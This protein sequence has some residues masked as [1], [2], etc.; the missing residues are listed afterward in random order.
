MLW[1]SARFWSSLSFWICS[2]FAHFWSSLSIWTCS[3][4]CLAVL[5]CIFSLS[6]FG[7]CPPVGYSNGYPKRTPTGNIHRSH[8]PS[9]CL[10]VTL[11]VS[12]AMAVSGVQSAGDALRAQRR[13]GINLVADRVMRPQTRSRRDGLLSD[14]EKWLSTFNL[15]LSDVVDARDFDPERVS[16]LLVQYGRHLYYLGRPC[17]VYSETINAVVSPRPTLRRQVGQAWDLAFAW[18]AEEPVTHHPAMPRAILVAIV[19]LS[20]LWGW[21]HEAAIFM[22]AWAGLLRIGEATSATRSDL[23]LPCDS[24]PGSDFG[25]LR[26]RVPKTRGLAARHQAAR[27]DPHNLLDLS[28]RSMRTTPRT[29]FCG[30]TPPTLCG[31]G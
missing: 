4:V 30:P 6:L 18:V 27:L 28:P 3:S 10:F 14:F 2:A 11:C 29:S 21:P 24:A 22:M 20:L 16:S 26:I 19:G 23:I 13:A 9:V 12:Q 1:T 17:G 31:R 8:C 15:A 7:L 25:L 5:L